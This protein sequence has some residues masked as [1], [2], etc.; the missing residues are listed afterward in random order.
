M[1]NWLRL[2][3]DSDGVGGN[4]KQHWAEEADVLQSTVRF[5]GPEDFYLVKGYTGIQQPGSTSLAECVH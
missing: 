2:Q 1:S 4:V 3:F 5:P